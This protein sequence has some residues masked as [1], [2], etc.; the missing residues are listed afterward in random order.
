MRGYIS[1]SA[2]RVFAKERS[3]KL[4]RIDSVPFGVVLYCVGRSSF[5]SGYLGDGESARVFRSVESLRK[6]ISSRAFL[7]DV[8]VLEVLG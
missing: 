1:S 3:F 7:S 6:F 5:S 4:L 2:F 8:P